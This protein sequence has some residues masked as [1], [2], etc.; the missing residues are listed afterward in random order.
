MSERWEK[1]M[2]MLN[3][4]ALGDVNSPETLLRYWQMQAKAGYPLASENVKYFEEMVRHEERE[5]TFDYPPCTCLSIRKKGRAAMRGKPLDKDCRKAEWILWKPR[6]INRNATY[7]CSECG[8]LCS[9]YYNDVGSWKCCPH[10]MTPIE[11]KSKK[12][13][14]QR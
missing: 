10:C 1:N 7:K 6:R 13:G 8:K 12:G 14:E 9:S 11:R 5:K 2:E 4:G 3:S